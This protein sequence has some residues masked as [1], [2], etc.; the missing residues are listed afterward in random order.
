MLAADQS[1]PSGQVAID[2]GSDVTVAAPSPASGA[3]ASPPASPAPSPQG[4]ASITPAHF[5]V[6]SYDPT[7]CPPGH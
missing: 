6:T 4:A 1:V 2:V 7:A 3:T 5:P